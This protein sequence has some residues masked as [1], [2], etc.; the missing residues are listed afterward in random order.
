VK[1]DEVSDVAA[2]SQVETDRVSRKRTVYVFGNKTASHFIRHKSS[3][4]FFFS[5]GRCTKSE[6]VHDNSQVCEHTQFFLCTHMCTL[7]SLCLWNV[8][9]VFLPSG[10]TF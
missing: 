5:S 2:C 1:I 3:K 7:I 9:A 6:K 4:K 10:T 8:V